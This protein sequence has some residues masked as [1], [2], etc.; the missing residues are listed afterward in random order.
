MGIARYLA[1]HRDHP[2][3]GRG[4]REE[5]VQSISRGSPGDLKSDGFVGIDLIN[6][7]RQQE[8]TQNQRQRSPTISGSVST[9]K[10]AVA[11]SAA[12]RVSKRSLAFCALFRNGEFPGTGEDPAFEF[13]GRERAIVPGSELRRV[14]GGK[15][16]PLARQQAL[17]LE[18]RFGYALP[19]CIQNDDDALGHHRL[20][21]G[22]VQLFGKDRVR[23]RCLG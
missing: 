16:H 12:A 4:F 23:L 14:G 6:L 20:G 21:A 5:F 18:R 9:R 8:T 19:G 15:N 11:M 7:R 2:I 22:I 10:H 17:R 1:F 13:K 3:L